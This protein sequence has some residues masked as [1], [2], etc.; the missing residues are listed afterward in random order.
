MFVLHFVLPVYYNPTM[1]GFRRRISATVLLVKRREV[2]WGR[3]GVY[4]RLKS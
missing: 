4:V 3:G 2:I 1:T